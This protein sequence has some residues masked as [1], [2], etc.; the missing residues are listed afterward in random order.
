MTAIYTTRPSVTVPGSRSATASLRSLALGL[1][2]GLA[3][4]CGSAHAQ[5][6]AEAAAASKGPPAG[7]T[8]PALPEA[9]ENNAQ[10]A[11]TQPGNNAPFWRAVRESG[12]QPGTISLPGNEQGVLV[13]AFTQ[14][15]GSQYTTAGEAWRQVRNNWIL[16]Y[17]GSLIVIV[18]LAMALF[19]KAKGSLGGHVPDT[20]RKIER[21]TPLERAAHWTNAIAFVVLA[22]SGV[23]M[24]FGKFFLLPVL[25]ATLFGWLSYAMKN[26]HNF[27]GPLFA[28]SLVIV[29]LTFIKDNWPSKEDWTWL[30]RAGGM[31][32]GHE[33]PS[34]RF[35]A[36]EKLVFW[37][38]VLFLGFIVVGS[39]LVLNML[40]PGMAYTRGEMQVAHMLHAVA[41]V[42]MM[43]MFLGHI[44][45]GTVGMKGAYGAM[46]TGYVDE[47]W[48]KEH[49][50][51]WY[52][53]I[54]AGKIPAHRSAANAPQDARLQPSAGAD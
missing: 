29:L 3:L 2:L 46:R 20:G 32:G 16:P 34:H 11:Q 40:V 10:R 39:G 37:G 5:A 36:G 54:Q 38:G 14:Y 41:S 47:G 51:L 8:A 7:F 12:N 9:G 23:V 22:V 25:G 27:A 19:Y 28:V 52:D 43:A 15:P 18:L 1:G 24:A 17:G 6:P 30:K 35:N 33:V 31:F 49:H 44:Y 4:V 53:D 26:L 48:A 21:F 13:Q 42:F 50:E 45:M